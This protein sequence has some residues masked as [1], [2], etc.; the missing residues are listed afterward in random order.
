MALWGNNDN[1]TSAGTVSLNYGTGVV[2]GSGTTFTTDLEVGQVI[3]FGLRAGTYFGDAVIVSIAGTQSLTIGST[4]GL[5]GAAIAATSFTASECPVYTVTDSVFSEAS[6]GTEDSF[7]YGVSAEGVTHAAN[8]KY[9][10]THSGWVGVTTYLD[11][12]G[13][14]RVKS[15]V[16]VAMSGIT[17]GN[18][19]VY[20]ADPTV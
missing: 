7:V 4:A 2:T 6:Y 16:L 13:N 18:A 12:G 1:V 5:S 20:D 11:N 15:E 14:L 8:T 9:D 19:P 10:A 3:R 17:T